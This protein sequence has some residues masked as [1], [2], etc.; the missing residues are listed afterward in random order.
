MGV[1]ATLVIPC[2]SLGIVLFEECG[3]RLE[4]LVV[5]LDEL[6]VS[7]VPSSKLASIIS[8]ARHPDTYFSL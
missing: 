1:N 6:D 3:K 5:S 4:D 8:R 7:A 2:Q